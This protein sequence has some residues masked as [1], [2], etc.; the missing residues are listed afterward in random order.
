[1]SN[2]IETLKQ[3]TNKEL[4][5]YCNK[6]DIPIIAKNKYKPSKAELLNS[7]K[8][9][10]ESDADDIAVET[11]EDKI[12]EI[13]TITDE[14]ENIEEPETNSEEELEA[15]AKK[16]AIAKI[17]EKT[18]LVRVIVR[19]NSEL[20]ENVLPN[21]MMEVSWGN[22]VVGHIYEKFPLNK[23]WHLT[24]GSVDA[25]KRITFRKPIINDRGDIE[26]YVDV[27]KYFIEELPPLS[28]E[29]LKELAKRQLINKASSN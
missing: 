28:K 4:V 20:R 29:E 15:D 25:L 23:P 22:S 14:P 2:L 7:I 6:N 18:A 17:K 8:K 9:F 19:L 16:D 24:K 26:G 27:K 13:D 11:I 21:Q 12:D 3:K 10:M 1:M 5:E